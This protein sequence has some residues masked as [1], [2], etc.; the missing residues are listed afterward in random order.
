MSCLEDWVSGSSQAKAK[1]KCESGCKEAGK[2]ASFRMVEWE[3][4]GERLGRG[5]Y[6]MLATGWVETTASLVRWRP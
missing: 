5:L 6:G 4:V 2:K 1:N 3:V